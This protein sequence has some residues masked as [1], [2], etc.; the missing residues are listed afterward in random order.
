MGQTFFTIVIHGKMALL[1]AGRSRGG[2]CG[3]GKKCN[4]HLPS[5]PAPAS[6]SSTLAVVDD[7]GN[8]SSTC[9]SLSHWALIHQPKLKNVQL[10]IYIFCILAYCIG[11]LSIVWQLSLLF[12]PNQSFLLW[13]CIQ[14][15]GQRIIGIRISNT[16]RSP[17]IQ[18]CGP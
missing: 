10:F 1:N 12:F 8:S 6:T 2:N 14:H 16:I 7:A 13:N 9:L 15:R 18:H 5:L 11:I 3:P 4:L 17:L